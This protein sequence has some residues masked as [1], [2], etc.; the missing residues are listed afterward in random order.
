MTS[1][2]YYHRESRGP[3]LLQFQL[4]RASRKALFAC[5]P[6]VG[7]RKRFHGLFAPFS[8]LTF[9]DKCAKV[10]PSARPF[11]YTPGLLSGLIEGKTVNSD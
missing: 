4:P 5:V 3:S 2:Y 6:V 9:T 11:F 8:A 10:S 7:M 1:H